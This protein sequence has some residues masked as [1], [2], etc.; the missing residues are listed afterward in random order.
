[1]IYAAFTVITIL[2]S[3]GYLP[4]ELDDAPQAKNV[5]IQ[6]VFANSTGVGFVLIFS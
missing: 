2:V 6:K 3:N 1:M 4:K 5:F